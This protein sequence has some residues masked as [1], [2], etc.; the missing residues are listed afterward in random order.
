[1][2]DPLGRFSPA[3]APKHPRH[4]IVHRHQHHSAVDS[5]HP[6]RRVP[7]SAQRGRGGRKSGYCGVHPL[8]DAVGEREKVV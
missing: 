8:V 3:L 4:T 1:L 7:K 6:K 2:T 5:P